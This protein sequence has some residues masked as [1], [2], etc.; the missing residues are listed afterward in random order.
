MSRVWRLPILVLLPVL[1]LVAVAV[2]GRS[3][4]D[5]APAVRLSELTP[6]AAP[7][8]T[9][10]STWYC[11]AGSATGA[12]TGEGAGPAEQTVIV[13]NAS[14]TASTGVI[15]LYPEGAAA[16]AVPIEIGAHASTSVKVSDQVKAAWAAAMVEVTGGEVSVAH[17]LVGATGQSV[18]DCASAPGAD[19]YFPGGT[20]R[21]GTAQWLALF[22]PFPG[23][24]T[25][26]LAFDTPDGART[27]QEYQGIVVPGGS[28]VV[29]KVSD[30]VTLRD[31]VS[32]TVSARSG[33]VVAEQV[34]ALEGREGG[35][36][37]LTA[38]L[39]ATAPSPV[40]SFPMSAPG[41]VDA[42]ESVAVFNPGDT[43]TDV[44]VQVQLDAP[45]VNGTVE[46][47]EVSVP[48]H[49]FAVVDVS[50]DERVPPGVAH[51]LVV[52]TP[53]GSEI[54]AQR[55]LTGGAGGGY[56]TT[57]GMPVVATRWLSPVANI[58][59]ATSPQLS[60]A[61][62]SPTETATF[63]VR[64]SGAGSSGDVDGAVDLTVAPGQ[65]V[66]IALDGAGFEPGSTAEVV[67]DRPVVV[68]LWLTLASPA[69]VATP[70]GVPVGG[71][72]SLPVEVV[73][74]TVAATGQLDTGDSI[75]GSLT[76]GGTGA[77]ATDGS[78]TTTSADA[79][80]T[81]TAAGAAST[82]TTAAAVSSTTTTS[83]AG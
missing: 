41:G 78:S 12:T 32:T 51:W 30:V 71:S 36:K 57:I 17:Q 43:D 9:L 55:T 64:R 73:G 15:T 2:E 34:Q 50:A 67:S 21:V 42:G 63:T 75:P 8:G 77:A 60:V 16:K 72:Q 31:E 5:T 79:A 46:P 22:N 81:T 10:S 20:T 25:V 1:V 6:T 38:T 35:P 4:G 24:A 39:G 26:D 28:V 37:G 44:L 13:S 59:G 48:A 69:D 7:S 23:E 82:T 74:P 11:A 65:R 56:S 52:S 19:W 62:P 33:R 14:D 54:V 83:A 18:S 61:N 47:F 70:L 29:K 80:S 53:G 66:V 40:W 58:A 45:E 49:R 3:D 76:D 68:G 27:P